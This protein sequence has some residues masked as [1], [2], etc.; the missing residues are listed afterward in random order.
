HQI[1][2]H[3]A[4]Q[5]PLAEAYLHTLAASEL[6]A[7]TV[8]IYEEKG[9]R[10]VGVYANALKFLASEAQGKATDAAM[11][12]HGGFAYAREY[13]VGRHWIEARLQRLAPINNQM[14]LNSIAEVALG[15]PRSY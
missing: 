14:V 5:H 2:R 4:V 12:V 8:E 6:L 9:G 1:G 10:A 3:Q 15:L 7:R 11:Q 13:H